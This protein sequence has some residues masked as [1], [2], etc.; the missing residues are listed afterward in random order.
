MQYINIKTG[1]TLTVTDPVTIKLMN[2]SDQYKPVEEAPAAPAKKAGA[3][4]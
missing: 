2:A 1:N 4:G 3:K